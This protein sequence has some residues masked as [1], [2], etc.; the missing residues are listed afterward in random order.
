MVTPVVFFDGD[1]A[2]CTRSVR[3][4]ARH[5]AGRFSFAPLHG[6]TFQQAF[7]A[8]AQARLPDSIV[9]RTETGAVLIKGL[10]VAY[11]LRSSPWPWRPLGWLLATI[12][13]PLVNIGYDLVAGR[14]HR[15]AAETC[16]IPTPAFRKRVLP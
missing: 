16:E 2:F 1:C 15:I 8:A 9:V 4:V 6:E 3:W 13:T 5:D 11:I 7:D 14:R 12:P 10:A